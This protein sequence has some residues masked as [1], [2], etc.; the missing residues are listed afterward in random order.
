MRKNS[1]EWAQFENESEKEISY[2]GLGIM[3]E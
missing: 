2:A 3:R 1:N